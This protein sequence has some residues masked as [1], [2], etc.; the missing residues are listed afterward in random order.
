MSYLE[1]TWTDD[2]TGI[3]GYIVVD[4]L[5]RGVAGGGLRMRQGVTIE[6][7]RD[8]ARG[9]TLKDPVLW[10]DGDLYVPF[11]GGK[12]GIDCDPY[13]P[14]AREV[15]RRWARAMKP[16]IDLCFATGEDF[17]VRQDLIDEVFAEEGI[18][19]SAEAGYRL[20]PGGAEAALARQETAF[21]V[22]VDGVG[23]S[24]LI[25]GFGVAE[26]ALAALEHRG[27]KP[28]ESR[29]VVQ[30]FGSMGGATARY[31]A[32]A[33][34]SVVGIADREGVVYNPRGL[35]VETLLLTRDSHGV[36]DRTQLNADDQQ[37]PSEQW[38]SCDAEILV[39]AAMSYVIDVDD[40][41]KIRATIIVEAANVSTSVEA[42][43][44]LRARGTT[45]IPD[46]LANTGTNQWWWWVCF[47]DIEPTALSAFTMLSS[48]MRPTV[49]TIL[50]NADRDGI[51]PREAATRLSHSKRAELD[52]RYPRTVN[53]AELLE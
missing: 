32:L 2:D 18:R 5:S 11:G 33:G 36:V 42:E 13:D 29:A 14:R 51:S 47:G 24:E 45:V 53:A 20:A 6:E 49:R 30:G 43:D 44:A 1:V 41:A 50:A 34:V 9:M 8:L 19:S 27:M 10:Q 23:L 7:V 40:V 37:I 17:G 28:S 21:A 39:P 46:F 38:L 48:R 3:N 22:R 25:G 31:L 35:E 52:L 26:A 4:R 15:L 12:G 16:V